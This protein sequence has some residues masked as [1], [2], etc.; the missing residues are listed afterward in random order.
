M[1]DSEHYRISNVP[2]SDEVVTHMIVHPCV[3]MP[4]WGG[5]IELRCQ[6][7]PSLGYNVEILESSCLAWG[8][9][10]PDD[11][12]PGNIYMMAHADPKDLATQRVMAIEPV[13][14]ITQGGSFGDGTQFIV[15][16]AMSHAWL[17]GEVGKTGYDVSP[18]TPAADWS[19]NDI[20]HVKARG[21]DWRI[22][23]QETAR[24]IVCNGAHGL[25][26]LFK[27]TGGNNVV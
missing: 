9:P 25:S 2:T 17:R 10:C 13:E 22:I 20:N 12:T 24:D 18:W 26:D 4:F 21:A 27:K 23:D 16:S 1:R 8:I 3:A 6:I 7:C 15:I 11:I 19:V 5:G 14:I